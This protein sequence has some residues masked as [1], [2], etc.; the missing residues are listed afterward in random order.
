MRYTTPVKIPVSVAFVLLALLAGCARPQYYPARAT[1]AYPDHLH[2]PD[3]VD[4]HVFRDSTEIEVVNATARSFRNFRLW[5]NQRYMHEVDELLAGQTRRFSLWDFYDERGE[6]MNAGGF[7]RI[8]EPDPVRLVQIQV[9]EQ[10][11]LIG[12]IA[13]RERRMIEE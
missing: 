1:T 5:I 7:W 12:L 11:P 6:V 2:R 4:I 9:D 13:V 8:Y 10:T 3:A